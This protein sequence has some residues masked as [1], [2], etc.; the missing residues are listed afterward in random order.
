MNQLRP[1][2]EIT[3][4]KQSVSGLLFTHLRVKRDGRLLHGCYLFVPPL[5]ADIG[6][7]ECLKRARRYAERGQKILTQM[8]MSTTRGLHA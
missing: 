1:S 6:Y 2:L 8:Y 5:D 7:D 4:F 3:E